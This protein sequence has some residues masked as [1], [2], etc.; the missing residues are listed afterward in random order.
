[1]L[2]NSKIRLFF[3]LRGVS[4]E[5]ASYFGLHEETR[6]GPGG[7]CVFVIDYFE[8]R[9]GLPCQGGNCGPEKAK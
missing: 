8:G 5:G 4:R 1:M 3:F 2:E 7:L 9:Q 6:S